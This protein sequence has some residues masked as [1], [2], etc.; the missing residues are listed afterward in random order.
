[1][2]SHSLL[3]PSGGNGFST[4]GVNEEAGVDVLGVGVEVGK[5]IGN[6]SV[7]S[8]LFFFGL[9][10]GATF[11][12]NRQQKSP[13]TSSSGIKQPPPKTEEPHLYYSPAHKTSATT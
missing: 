13:L 6:I 3:H 7:L 9:G 5:P 1:M 10:S 11:T 8:S 2:W 4:V 12:R